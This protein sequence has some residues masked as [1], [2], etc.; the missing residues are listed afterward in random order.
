MKNKITYAITV[1]NE[2]FE[3]DR[4]LTQLQ[5]DV[6]DIQDHQILIQYDIDSVTSDVMD[7]ISKFKIEFNEYTV[8]GFRLNKH[9]ANFKNNLFDHAT[10]NWILQI[11]ADEYLE[12]MLV[13]K[14]SYFLDNSYLDDVDVILLPRINVVNGLTQE[15]VD[16]WRWIVH[17]TNYKDY[18]HMINFPDFQWRLYR[19]NSNLRWINAVHEVLGGYRRHAVCTIEQLNWALIHIKDIQKQEKQ[20][21]FYETI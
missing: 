13:S 15:H 19:N 18:P 8:V 20:N 3:L 21:Y 11:D 9:F 17:D 6:E 10:G 2:S 16:T 12:D 4:L 5:H 1:C 14:L 7:I